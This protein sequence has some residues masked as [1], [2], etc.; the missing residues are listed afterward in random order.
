LFRNRIEEALRL[1][2]L[3]GDLDEYATPQDGATRRRPAQGRLGW[4]EVATLGAADESGASMPSS[5][6]RDTVS[7]FRANVSLHA[8]LVDPRRN[9]LVELAGAMRP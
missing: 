6:A 5:S 4:P 9:A 1:L 3:S 7:G 2:Q 8:E